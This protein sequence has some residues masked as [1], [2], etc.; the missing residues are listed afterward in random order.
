MRIVLIVDSGWQ[1]YRRV[2]SLCRCKEL[3]IAS[4]GQR[5]NDDQEED[6]MWHT[7]FHV[8]GHFELNSVKAARTISVY[9]RHDVT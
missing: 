1:K 3:A 5:Q 9:S 4:I 2:G 6:D 7:R 8:K